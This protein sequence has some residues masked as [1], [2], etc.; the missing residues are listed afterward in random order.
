[1]TSALQFFLLLKY[2]VQEPRYDKCTEVIHPCLNGG[3]CINIYVS[4]TDLISTECKCLHPFGGIS[5]AKGKGTFLNKIIILFGKARN[6]IT[7]DM[8]PAFVGSL[9]KICQVFNAFSYY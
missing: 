3:V 7:K 8:F 9:S 2:I 1:M 6:D 4:Y 5:C